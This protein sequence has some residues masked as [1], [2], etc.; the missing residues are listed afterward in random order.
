MGTR[1]NPLL[2]GGRV[3]L[4]RTVGPGRVSS[5]N[6][7][8]SFRLFACGHRV[9]II[10]HSKVVEVEN[11]TEIVVVSVSMIAI[12]V[13]LINANSMAKKD[14]FNDLKAVVEQLRLDLKEAKDELAQAK[15][16][17]KIEQERNDELEKVL[18]DE[19]DKR[20]SFEVELIRQRNYSN[21]LIRQ[22]GQ[23]APGIKPVSF[24]DI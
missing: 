6:I 23:V 19:R 12:L 15:K 14:A 2:C 17:L 9:N 22:M 11:I 16:E 7:Q 5:P 24:D 8:P 1:H 18:A 13:S 3:Y 21:R 10:S 4:D 20:E